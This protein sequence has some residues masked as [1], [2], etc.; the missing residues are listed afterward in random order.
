MW[1]TV[2]LFSLILLRRFSWV[3][4]GTS[5]LSSSSSCEYRD[6]VLDPL[7]SLWERLIQPVVE[8]CVLSVNLLSW[9]ND[10]HGA[11]RNTRVIQTGSGG[12]SVSCWI[13]PDEFVLEVLVLQHQIRSVAQ[14]CPTLWDPMN[15]S[16]PGF[17]IHHQLLEFT[18]T[19]IHRV[20]DAI[21]PSH[22]L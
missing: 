17:P 20:S 10:P 15:R 22:P 1:R 21:Q 8:A 18:Q 16:M 2:A 3:N 4:V 12:L 7:I 19:H 5:F 11:E 13:S 14:S 6:P 9:L